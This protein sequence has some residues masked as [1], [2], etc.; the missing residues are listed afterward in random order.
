MKSRQLVC[1][2]LCLFATGALA[3]G[4]LASISAQDR[5]SGLKAA[6]SQAAEVAVTKLGKTDGF[7]GNPELRIPLP[8]KLEKARKTLRKI[9]LNK[10]ADDLALALNR[11]AEAAVPEAK[12]LFVDS[13]RQMSV[14]DAMGILT[15]PQDAA[16]QFFRKS[17]S[18]KLTERFLP[19]V[20]KATEKVQLAQRYNDVAGKASVLGVVDARDANL[21]SYVTRKTLD[22]LFATM[23]KEEASIRAN[24]LGQASSLLQ[25]VFGAIGK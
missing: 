18:D 4:G 3:A 14:E 2:A 7:F 21:D 20:G 9:G 8:G 16:T 15:G 24:P 11:A 5:S 12:A 13:I 25:K 22:G 23:A 17:M 1:A 6:L 10:Q 19:I